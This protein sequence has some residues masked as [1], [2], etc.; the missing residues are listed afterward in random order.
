MSNLSDR[1]SSRPICR[2][3]A[4][5]ALD[6]ICQELNALISNS[7][8]AGNMP[9]AKRDAVDSVLYVRTAIEALYIHTKP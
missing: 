1:T 5:K 4:Q 9:I 2:P 6:R 8:N 7:P 3:N